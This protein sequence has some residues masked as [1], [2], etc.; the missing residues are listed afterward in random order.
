MMGEGLGGTEEFKTERQAENKVKRWAG[1]EKETGVQRDGALSGSGSK[2][3]APG[4]C[5]NVNSTK[6]TTSAALLL[7]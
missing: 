2:T 5:F 3:T 4:L 7:Y 6:R 1:R